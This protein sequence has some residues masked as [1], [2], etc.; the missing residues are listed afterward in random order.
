MRLSR[1]DRDALPLDVLD[2]I[3]DGAALCTRAGIPIV[4]NAAL[5][6][7]LRVD[8]EAPRLRRELALLAVLAPP[9]GLATPE[10]APELGTPCAR[11][12]IRR[13]VLPG[14]VTARRCDLVLLLVKRIDRTP[15][16]WATLQRRF[17]LTNRECEVAS[18][19]HEGASNDAIASRL[20]VS[21]STARHHTERVL[22]KLGAHSRAQVPG[23]LARAAR[24]PDDLP[25]ASAELPPIADRADTR[26]RPVVGRDLHAGRDAPVE[27]A[28]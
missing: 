10:L 6:E 3:D 26:P 18:L 15:L 23:V 17:R 25:R 21:A 16:G 9:I 11:Y 8:P 22:R 19:L 5:T 28:D 24:I 4:T 2:A 20:A 27:R 14:T 12:R 1:A 13:W 7:M